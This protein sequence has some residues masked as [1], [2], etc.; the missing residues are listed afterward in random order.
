MSDEICRWTLRG[1]VRC[2]FQIMSIA[3]S[4]SEEQITQIQSWADDGD[5]LSEIQNKL[6]SEMDIRVTYM[7]MR[8]L[9][10]DIGVQL[11]SDPEPEPEE[12]EEEQQEEPVPEVPEQIAPEPTDELSEPAPEGTPAEE[13]VEVS[14]TVDQVQRP[15]TMISGIVSFGGDNTAEWSLDQMGQLGMKPKNEGFRPTEAQVMAFQQE[16]Q[17]V[18]QKS[19]Y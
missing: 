17:K 14:V 4:L 3:K 9:I 10:D 15:G 13:A 18:V 16:L 1:K 5:G 7:E 2:F 8:F 6:G 12:P 19:G 11:Q